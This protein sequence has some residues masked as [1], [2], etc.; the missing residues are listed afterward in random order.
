MSFLLTKL[1]LGNVWEWRSWK[2][3]FDWWWILKICFTFNLFHFQFCFSFNFVSSFVQLNFVRIQTFE[4]YHKS[5][6][7]PP[8]ILHHTLLPI[9]STQASLPINNLWI[10]LSNKKKRFSSSNLVLEFRFRNEIKKFR[11]NFCHLQKRK[12]NV[13]KQVF[14][15]FQ[16]IFS[17]YIDF[18]CYFSIVCLTKLGF[19]PPPNNKQ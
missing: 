13:I 6:T 16:S 11:R 4:I 18:L 1:C 9:D 3:N 2:L 14:I 10:A 17:H 19:A 15:R 7:N 5:T 12:K 8:Q